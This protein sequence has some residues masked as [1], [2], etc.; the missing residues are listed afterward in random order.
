MK[1]C[2]KCKVNKEL[3]EFRKRPLSERT[4]SWC[5]DCERHDNNLRQQ[6]CQGRNIDT[7]REYF[8]G[9]DRC[10]CCGKK[11]SFACG[12]QEK[13][14]CFDHREGGLES[15]QGSPMKWL[16]S[17]PKNDVNVWEFESCGFGT[18]CNVCNRAIPTKDRRK[19]LDDVTR[20]V[21]TEE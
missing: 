3:S 19:W 10:Q 5:N 1:K 4:Q 7:W 12:D 21:L 6:R 13:S 20:Y 16:M 11:I 15:I 9:R 14:I 2:T 18:L 8:S 17:N